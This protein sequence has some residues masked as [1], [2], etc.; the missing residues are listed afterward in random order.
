MDMLQNKAVGILN[1]LINRLA[2]FLAGGNCQMKNLYSKYIGL[3]I[4]QIFS[5]PNTF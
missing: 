5:L 3:D 4:A 1:L 2:K